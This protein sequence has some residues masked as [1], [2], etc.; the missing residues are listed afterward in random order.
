MM[1]MEHDEVAAASGA[2]AAI[3]K[4]MKPGAPLQRVTE[5][6]GRLDGTAIFV[7]TFRRAPWL[8][9]GEFFLTHA[10][11]DHMNGLG[12]SWRCGKLHCSMMTSAFLIA[13]NMCAPEV[14]RAHDLNTQF[15]VED[16]LHSRRKLTG[17]FVDACHC[18]GSVMIVLEGLPG[19]PVVLTGDFRFSDDHLHNSTLAAIRCRNPTLYLDVTFASSHPAC[20]D[21]PDKKCAIS[22]LLDLLDKHHG[23]TILMY[24]H[25]LGDEELLVAVAD[26][27]R[28][29]GDVLHFACERRFA[30]FKKIDP[31]FF[32]TV[33]VCSLTAGRLRS[34][35]SL[36]WIPHRAWNAFVRKGST[37]F[38]L[39]AAHFGGYGARTRNP[40]PCLSRHITSGVCFGRCIR[41]SRSFGCSLIGCSQNMFCQVAQS[42][43][44]KVQSRRQAMPYLAI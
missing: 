32:V 9:G 6:L 19:G 38:R 43:Y 28:P 36:S 44:L 5:S 31:D 17:V 26:Y 15:D 24:S 8:P 4:M 35:V 39:L 42:S 40:H 27:I 2:I 41:H 33:I 1:F 29:D 10:H 25:G 14:I 23:E 13:K 16:P 30:M 7:D 34:L 12:P 37:A 22:Q 21:F 3:H 11:T 20:R 18:P